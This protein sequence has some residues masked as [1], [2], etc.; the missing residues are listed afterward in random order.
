[1]STDPYDRWMPK[2]AEVGRSPI[3]KDRDRIIHSSAFRRLQGKSQVFGAH[4]TDYFRNRLTHSLECA[5]I[6][7]ALA[8]RSEASKWGAC[9][10]SLEDFVALCEA[11]C[12]AHDI[13]HP[14]FGHNGETALSRCMERYAGSLF[15]GNA[16]SFHIATYVEPKE[17]FQVRP[18]EVRWLGLNLTRTTLKAICKYPWTEEDSR[19]DRIKPKFSIYEDPVDKE[20]FGW[21]WGD[22]KPKKILA[23]EIMDIADDIGYA[24]HD[25]EDGVWSGMIPLYDLVAK[26]S[27]AA[28]EIRRKLLEIR[29]GITIKE[30]ENGLKQ[31]MDDAVKEAKLKKSERQWIKRPFERTRD[32]ISY[33]KRLSAAMI[34]M[35]INAV[36]PEG[37]FRKPTKESRTRVSID[38][39]TSIAWVWMIE[40]TDLTTRQFGQRKIIRELFAGYV[41]DPR[42]LPRQPEL[43]EIEELAGSED[44]KKAKTIRLVRDHIAGMTD[45]YALRAHQ[46]M[47]RGESPFEL[48]F[49]Y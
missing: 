37:Q 33:L 17:I 1:M 40:R 39:L 5:Q 34:G 48:R 9:A 20:Y 43:R 3:E 30:V 25:F 42:M 36:T 19:V 28:V 2:A 8:K 46:E 15:E 21:M 26:D 45:Q 41:R 7:R 10:E 14:P 31:L 6:G 49:S 35:F 18:T 32:N 12:L 16:Q 11:A 44:E 13:G 27:A 23:T 29:P 24:T 4:T 47:F 22:E 38:I